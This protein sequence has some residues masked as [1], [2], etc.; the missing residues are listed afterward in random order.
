MKV[1]AEALLQVIVGEQLGSVTFVQ[2][3]VQLAFDGSCL[4]AVTVPTVE[5][6]GH[7]F[8]WGDAGYRD[9][10]CERIARRVTAA[11][12]ERGVAIVI[13]FDDGAL[14]RVSLRAEDLQGLSAESA[15]FQGALGTP[16]VVF[17]PGEDP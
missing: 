16:L 4:T 3:Y 6:A 11:R 13:A 12:I 10:L 14:V 5:A 2:D 17:R 1:W 8:R 15:T 7:T 9:E